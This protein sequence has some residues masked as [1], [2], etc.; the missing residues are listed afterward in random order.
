[1]LD[2]LTCGF[3]VGVNILRTITFVPVN[4]KDYVSVHDLNVMNIEF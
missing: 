4:S 1:M 2:K 3:P